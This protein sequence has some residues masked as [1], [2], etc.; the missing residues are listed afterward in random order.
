MSGGPPKAEPPIEGW[1][2]IAAHVELT[3]PTAWR[4][5]RRNRDP[6]PVWSYLHTVIAW[7][8]ALTE[9]RARQILPVPVSDR[10]KAL[11][12]GQEAERDETAENNIEETRQNKRRR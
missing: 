4:M 5:A 9:W 10:M 7:P 12:D 3:V 2:L 8:S 6:L 11:G 1:K